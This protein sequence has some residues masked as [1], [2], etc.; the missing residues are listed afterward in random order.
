MVQQ[1][2]CRLTDETCQW[3]FPAGCF[4]N[5]FLKCVG[6]APACPPDAPV[7]YV[8]SEYG[9]FGKLPAAFAAIEAR[10]VENRLPV[11][12]DFFKW[13]DGNVTFSETAV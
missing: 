8:K 3:F 12:F 7:F 10:S 11:Q 4:L 1:T 5:K 6:P 2:V 13:A 9:D